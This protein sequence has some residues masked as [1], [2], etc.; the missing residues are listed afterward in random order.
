MCVHTLNSNQSVEHSWHCAVD[1]WAIDNCINTWTALNIKAMHVYRGGTDGFTLRV[2]G[3]SVKLPLCDCLAL[4]LSLSLSCSFTL[5]L[6]LRM[7]TSVGRRIEKGL[8]LTLSFHFAFHLI[9]FILLILL[10]SCFLQYLF[11]PTFFI[12]KNFTIQWICFPPFFH[13]FN[14]LLNF[15]LSFLLS[16]P[17]PL[18]SLLLFLTFT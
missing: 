2:C 18:C 5:T 12:L 4:S 10:F 11:Y 17:P 16:F 3:G 13:F 15:F 9:S 7:K 1:K 14:C 6:I 8:L